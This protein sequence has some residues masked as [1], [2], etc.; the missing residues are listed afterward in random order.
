MRGGDRLEEF[1]TTDLLDVWTDPDT[2]MEAVGASLGILGEGVSD[3]RRELSSDSPL[4]R[5]LYAVLLD[6]VDGGALEKRA[7]SDGWH[8][9]RW[10][11]DIASAAFDADIDLTVEPEP[12]PLLPPEPAPEPRLVAVPDVEPI[13]RQPDPVRRWPR[14][15]APAAPLLFPAISCILALVAFVWLDLAGAL[16]IA[17]A[18]TIVGVVGL[19][20]RVPFA[21]LWIVGVLVAGLVLRFS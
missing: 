15:V 18:L 9:F 12:L 19:L 2:A 7:T 5:A 16:I 11:E 4:R 6:L 17:A 14:V 13:A 1:V 20:R 3:V 21:G 10:R 8:A